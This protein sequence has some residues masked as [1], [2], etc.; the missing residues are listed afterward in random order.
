MANKY[1][2]F[3]YRPSLQYVYERLKT[4]REAV[5]KEEAEIVLDYIPSTK[6]EIMEDYIDLRDQFYE[7]YNE[8]YNKLK[9]ISI[10]YRVTVPS[11]FYSILQRYPGWDDFENGRQV[12]IDMYDSIREN[13]ILAELKYNLDNENKGINGNI[14]MEFYDIL[15]KMNFLLSFYQKGLDKTLFLWYNT[16]DNDDIPEKLLE[17]SLLNIEEYLKNYHDREDGIKEQNNEKVIRATKNMELLDKQ[18]NLINNILYVTKQM[19]S[20]LY[21]IQSETSD[22]IDDD[23]IEEHKEY[24]EERAKALM[25]NPD[26]DNNAIETLLYSSFKGYKKQQEALEAD[27]FSLL[28]KKNIQ[29]ECD[30]FFKNSKYYRDI[31][32][33]TINS[34]KNNSYTNTYG[35]LNS[36]YDGLAYIEN[37]YQKSMVEFS[38]FLDK[39]FSY[40]S[41]STSNLY[42][43]NDS[44]ALFNEFRYLSE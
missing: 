9:D 25:Q 39:Y 7:Y 32:S 33:K 34:L 42:A 43:K 13:P 19:N 5:G 12:T 15:E 3:T 30:A 37:E 36:L 6:V 20:I 4:I 44:R 26:L 29:N 38:T 28:S 35:Y 18:I 41:S 10:P 21:F 8:Y 16:D 23:S 24:V 31:Y 14:N 1:N 40:I 22:I 17:N 2:I 11:H 27:S